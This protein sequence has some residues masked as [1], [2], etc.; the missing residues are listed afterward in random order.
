MSSRL[1]V[2]E[3][4]IGGTSHPKSLSKLRREP[5]S[6]PPKLRPIQDYRCAIAPALPRSARDVG[7]DAVTRRI[8]LCAAL[9]ALMFA[10]AATAQPLPPPYPG[11]PGYGPGLPP[12][13]VIAI[14]RSLGL[15][16]LTRPFRTGPSYALRALDPAGQE[17]RVVVDARLGRVLGVVPVGAHRALMPPPSPY[18]RP[19]G[20]LAPDGYGPNSR[21]AGL[22]PG[23]DGPM[24]G[25]PAGA[26]LLPRTPG[27]A[28]AAHPSAQAG[29]PLPR[30]RP[31]IASATA[32][33]EKP[34]P[35]DAA[36]GS[37]HTA[38]EPSKTPAAPPAAAP[39]TPVE[40]AE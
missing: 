9:L 14:V 37:N 15:E 18:G 1:V 8:A 2:Q 36:P 25:D 4:Q 30:P 27:A 7:S 20:R 29:P 32:A 38:A 24:T 39:A 40:L 22:P 33:V 16:P 10:G 17:V 12:Y 3:L 31:K 11:Y 13:E 34:A 26:I 5:T 35:V 19:V 21:I 23:I 28:A 6:N